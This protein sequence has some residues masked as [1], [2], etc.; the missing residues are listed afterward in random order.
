MPSKKAKS[1]TNDDEQHCVRCHE[2]FNLG[3][4]KNKCIVE[5][6]TELFEGSRNGTVWYTGTL[7]C[8]G[9]SYKFHRH[10]SDEKADPKYC[11]EGTHTTNAEEVEY[12]DTTVKHCTKDDCGKEFHAMTKKV[13]D[14][15]MERKKR[16]RETQKAE[17]KKEKASK[18]SCIE[19]LQAE[20]KQREARRLRAEMLGMDPDDDELDSDIDPDGCEEF[21]CASDSSIVPPWAMSDGDY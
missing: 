16:A 1:R 6:D 9:A 8:C 12:N 21:D 3:D 19:T 5:H 4:K 11:F 18:R 14:E 2:T 15:Q 7:G 13:Y 20:G 17:R 10:Y